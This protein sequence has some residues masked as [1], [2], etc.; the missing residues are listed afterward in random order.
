[1]RNCR[2]K[3]LRKD[4]KLTQTEFGEKIGKSLQAIQQ[5]EY[6][7]RNINESLILLICKIFNVNREWLV[8]GVGNIFINQSKILENSI[9]VK[10]YQDIRA[11]A[12]YGEYNE[13]ETYIDYPLYIGDDIDYNNDSIIEISGT[14]MTPTLMDSDRVLVNMKPIETLMLDKIYLILTDDLLLVKR[15][16]GALENSYIFSSDNS[17]YKNIYLDRSNE[18]NKIIGNVKSIVYRKID[19]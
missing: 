5:Y 3:E 13:V 2:L 10:Y 12:G 8:D 7:I 1:M 11:A 9:T 19:N 17:S 14:S 4:L 16:A 6:G 18:R 15:Y